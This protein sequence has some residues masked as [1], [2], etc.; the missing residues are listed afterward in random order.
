MFILR[1]HENIEGEVR[2]SQDGRWLLWEI[3]IWLEVLK[4]QVAPVKKGL[5]VSIADT[6]PLHSA[7][8]IDAFLAK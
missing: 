5:L 6:S 3:N 8:L 7:N 4:C 1:G 2:I